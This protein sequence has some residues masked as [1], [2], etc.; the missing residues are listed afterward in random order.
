[1]DLDN[2]QLRLFL[3]PL[4]VRVRVPDEFLALVVG[5]PSTKELVEAAVAAESKLLKLAPLQK[6]ALEKVVSYIKM[7]K[8]SPR[9]L[10]PLPATLKTKILYEIMLLWI[11]REGKFQRRISH[12]LVL[13]GEDLMA[14][15]YGQAGGSQIL[16]V[17][18]SEVLKNLINPELREFDFK[19]CGGTCKKLTD[20]GI[21]LQVWPLLSSSPGKLESLRDRRS[22]VGQLLPA[23]RI[24]EHLI[25]CKNLRNL[26]LATVEFNDEDIRLL[27][28]NCLNLRSL[29]LRESLALTEVGLELLS[30]LPNLERMFFGST[31]GIK[32]KETSANMQ[33]AFE[34]LP[35]LKFLTD[36]EGYDYP[37]C[38]VIKQREGPAIKIESLLPPSSLE[39]I[40]SF[41][42]PVEK[43]P[44]LL[45]NLKEFC[46]NFHYTNE[47]KVNPN[48]LAQL[49]LLHKIQFSGIYDE[50]RLAVKTFT[51]LG[52]RLTELTLRAYID[53]DLNQIVNVCPNLEKLVVVG[54]FVTRAQEQKCTIP[55][56][57][58]KL[59]DL[60]IEG[61]GSQMLFWHLLLAPNLR[62]VGILNLSIGNLTPLLKAIRSSEPILQELV[63]FASDLQFQHEQTLV[64]HNTLMTTIVKGCPKLEN[65]SCHIRYSTGMSM[66]IAVAEIL[67]PK[68][69]KIDPVFWLVAN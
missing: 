30:T 13:P 15:N 46:V 22:I 5:S 26:D 24:I 52:S 32:L 3:V 1:M 67:E 63:S 6:L 28:I 27:T 35:R 2:P 44:M 49:P 14:T 7:S 31:P 19:L 4:R 10:I 20:R 58:L 42:G 37:S 21:D 62:T 29:T 59:K 53:V 51:Y 47:T 43:L 11:E 34:K 16:K 36:L 12:K 57:D 64:K 40:Y 60:V 45:P 33:K 68:K 61:E 18:M 9:S 56:R 65:F 50:Q 17:P 25:K 55:A 23:K 54:M 39:K 69:R 66:G 38:R 41:G 48:I 8:L